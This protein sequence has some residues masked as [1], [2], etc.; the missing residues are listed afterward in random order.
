MQAEF[1]SQR[2][3]PARFSNPHSRANRIARMGWMLAYTLLFRPTPWF[4]G[5]WRTWLLRRFG[6][7]IG[8]ARLHA[9]ARI[10]APWLL[11]IGDEVWIDMNVN[12]YNA[13]GLK[14]GNRVVVSQNTFLCS[15]THDYTDPRYRLTGGR[16]TIEDDCWVAADAF[17]APGVTVRQGAVVGAR[18]VVTK[19]VPPW[20]VVAGNPAKVIKQRVLK[21]G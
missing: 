14:I 19:E 21:D 2:T 16:I 4:M 10:W 1:A 12:L 11:E 5:A 7:R 15:A 17:V 13:F 9:S 8:Y 20:T 3:D 6:A 18:A